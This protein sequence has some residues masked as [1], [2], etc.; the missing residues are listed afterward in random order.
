[1]TYS[2][3]YPQANQFFLIPNAAFSLRYGA[4]GADDGGWV[5][6]NYAYTPLSASQI[7]V[8][9]KINLVNSASFDTVIHPMFPYHHLASLEMG[10]REKRWGFWTSVTRD[11][12]MNQDIPSTWIAR[13]LDPTTIGS[14]GARVQPARGLDLSSSYIISH[15]GLV[16]DPLNAT[17]LSRQPVYL[18]TQAV[19]FDVHW[20][21]ASRL[22]YDLTTVLDIDNKSTQVSLDISLIPK[23]PQGNWI[24]G[25]GF[26]AISS[27]SGQGWIGQFEGDD[28]VRW[29]LGYAF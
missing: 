20:Q 11:I 8:E 29:R 12:P 24:A 22:A 13:P 18:F 23:K 28:R 1:V 19:D 15:A 7:A 9:P 21:N 10:Y 3:A 26:D 4:Q 25:I 6:G 17:L 5:S 2:I 27:Q 14:V 16:L